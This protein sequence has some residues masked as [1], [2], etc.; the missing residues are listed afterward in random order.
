MNE[1]ELPKVIDHPNIVKYVE[2]FEDP[3][4]I[5]LILEYLEGHTLSKYV[6]RR[7]HLVEPL[8]KRVMRD[9]FSALSYLQDIGVV[10]RDIKLDNIV[11]MNSP[12]DSLGSGIVS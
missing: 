10:H 8:C 7:E 1:I 2:C 3:Q 6:V 5:Y 12:N 9:I 11:M 4:N